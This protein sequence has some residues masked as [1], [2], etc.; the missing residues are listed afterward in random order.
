MTPSDA[1]HDQDGAAAVTTL[2]AM[3]VVLS[4]VLGV[5]AAAGDLTTTT[6]RARATADAAALAAAGTSPLVAPAADE[7]PLAAARAVASA[8]GGT[9]V[10]TDD[11]QW[12]LRYGVTVEV[13]P[14]TGW[15]RRIIGPIR[16]RATGGVR[17]SLP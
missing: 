12:P 17:P 2:L 3:A 16:A 1:D 7:T 15:V 8:N 5:L 6:A 11:D 13:A 10:E 4:G 14:S 9:L